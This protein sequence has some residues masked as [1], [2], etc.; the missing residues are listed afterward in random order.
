MQDVDV[1]I[2]IRATQPNRWLENAF[3]LIR[4]TDKHECVLLC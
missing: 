4:V 3:N 1:M 2:C